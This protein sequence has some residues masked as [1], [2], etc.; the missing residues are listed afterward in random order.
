MLPL[1]SFAKLLVTSLELWLSSEDQS[2]SKCGGL[3]YR[4]IPDGSHINVQHISGVSHPSYV[5]GVHTGLSP[6]HVT[7]DLVC[8]AF[9][10]I[11][12]ILSISQWANHI[13]VWWLRL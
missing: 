8:Q 12:R 5:V 4:S 9:G 11:Q 2:T 3:S 6:Y 13:I 1:V 10:D 7:T